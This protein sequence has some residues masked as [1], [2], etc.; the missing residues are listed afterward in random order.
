MDN[1]IISH[2][3]RD[4]TINFKGDNKLESFNNII[5]KYSNDQIDHIGIEIDIQML[6]DG[7]LVCLHDMIVN[8]KK[9]NNLTY[10]QLV[11]ELGYKPSTLQQVLDRLKISPHIFIDFDIKYVDGDYK[12]CA[13]SILFEIFVRKMTNQCILTSFNIDILLQI[14]LYTKEIKVGLIFDNGDVENM[15][16]KYY[17]NMGLSC[18]VLPIGVDINNIMFLVNNFEIFL[19]TLFSNEGYDKKK[20]MSII[21]KSIG[22]K[23]NYITDNMSFFHNI[24][25]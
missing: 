2:R 9:T 14:L 22:N 7:S 4:N 18:V 3:G 23:I 1:I 19:Y 16:F 25:Y 15:D 13:S 11:V 17:K 6:K 20:D 24:N 21:S 10:E 12:K 8:E 5:D